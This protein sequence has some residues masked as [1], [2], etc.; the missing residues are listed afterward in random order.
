MLY[1]VPFKLRLVMGSLLSTMLRQHS[2]VDDRTAASDEDEECD[3]HLEYDPV[4]LAVQYTRREAWWRYE[5]LLECDR[6][7]YYMLYNETCMTRVHASRNI[8]E[9]GTVDDIQAIIVQPTNLLEAFVRMTVVPQERFRSLFVW[10]TIGHDAWRSL[11]Q[12]CRAAVSLRHIWC[13]FHGACCVHRQRYAISPISVE[14]EQDPWRVVPFSWWLCRNNSCETDDSSHGWT[15]EDSER[16]RAW[17][18]LPT[19]R[20]EHSVG[21]RVLVT[22]RWSIGPAS[23]RARSRSRSRSR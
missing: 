11:S 22:N 12:T 14:E 3:E 23:T 21:S 13:H 7:R 2:T 1:P 8:L 17:P 20:H 19:F 6:S 16:A 9:D 4:E 15:V 18:N 10:I 5:F